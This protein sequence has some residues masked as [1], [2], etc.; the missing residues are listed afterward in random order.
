VIYLIAKIFVYLLFALGLG[1]A[2]GW[3]WRNLQAAGREASVERAL[4]DA[5]S[6]LPQMDT[7]LRQSEQ[8]LQAAL[9]ELRSREDELAGQSD[10]LAARDRAVA[11]LERACAE[12]RERQDAGDRADSGGQP[13]V[14]DNSL[15]LHPGDAS[16][17]A[18]A[19]DAPLEPT[20]KVDPAVEEERRELQA[21]LAATRE[22]LE[23]AE[24]ALTSERRR[25]DELNQERELQKRSLEALE[26]QLEMARESHARAASG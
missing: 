17:P 10:A 16:A 20:S 15:E 4:M 8:R 1:V 23:R 5:R 11:D 14:E 6:R 19:A 9:V 7:A 24:R 22:E 3:L 21:A 26:Q 2:A 12:L 25:V 13:R 18:V